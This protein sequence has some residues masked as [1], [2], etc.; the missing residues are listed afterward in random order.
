[1]RRPGL[2]VK[3]TVFIFFISFS[4]TQNIFNPNP[5][6]RQLFERSEMLNEEIKTDHIFSNKS[7]FQL[8][9][10]QSIYYNSN[11]PNFEKHNGLYLP[12]GSG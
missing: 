8:T 11:H 9:F 1:M 2:T 7:F 10:N 3:T 5:T 12:K 6:K 4:F